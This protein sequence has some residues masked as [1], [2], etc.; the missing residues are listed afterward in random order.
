M[1]S[2]L[3]LLVLG[4]VAG[5][6]VTA[7]ALPAERLLPKKVPF[8]RW[9]VLPGKQVGLLVASVSPLG[10]SAGW[11]RA[12]TPVKPTPTRA[13][14]HFFTDGQSP[15]AVYFKS[16]AGRGENFLKGWGVP[17]PGG[18]QALFD[19]AMFLPSTKN[20]WGLHADAHLVEVTVNGGKGAASGLHFVATKVRVLDG[21]KGY[22]VAAQMLADARARFDAHIAAQEVPLKQQ[23]ALAARKSGTPL[24]PE[25]EQ[26]LESFFP[27]WL[28][29]ER[30]LHVLHVRR[31]VRSSSKVERVRV[32]HRCPPGAPCM[33]PHEQEQRV[34]RGYGVDVGM[35]LVYDAGGQL[36][37]V[38]PYTP[39]ILDRASAVEQGVIV[40][41]P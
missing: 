18:K 38:Q 9:P 13:A 10:A 12:L 26:V 23:M 37:K 35:E 27:T 2:L 17:L 33:P 41:R 25:T 36:L 14:Y 19:A 31:V 6:D 16:E 5:A 4:S 40:P 7:P 22:P 3:V 32:V 21:T 24:G 1:R 8:Q 11:M 39:W 20:A 34:V 15:W 28:N 30:Q 29:A